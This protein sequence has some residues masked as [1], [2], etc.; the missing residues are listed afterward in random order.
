MVQP[1][2]LSPRKGGATPSGAAD[3]KKLFLCPHRAV[4]PPVGPRLPSRPL[5][6]LGNRPVN[7]LPQWPAPPA[8]KI[9]SIV[10]THG[11]HVWA[12][13]PPVWSLTPV[14]SVS[15]FSSFEPQAHSQLRALAPAVPSA[16]DRLP[17]CF[18]RADS[19]PSGLGTKVTSSSKPFLIP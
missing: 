13:R 11:L 8:Q 7:H 15:P 5:P 2:L 17:P 3:G 1:L 14:P 19:C 18:H 10:P 16:W 6:H 4:A 9:K 12:L